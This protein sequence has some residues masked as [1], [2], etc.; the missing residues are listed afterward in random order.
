MEEIYVLQE[1]YDPA[2]MSQYRPIDYGLALALK[3]TNIS[4]PYFA[5]RWLFQRATTWI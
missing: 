2:S 4:Q 5:S 3:W 1:K